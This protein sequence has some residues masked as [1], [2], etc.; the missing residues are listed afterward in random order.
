MAGRSDDEALR[1][2]SRRALERSLRGHAETMADGAH[3]PVKVAR[4]E[5]AIRRLSPAEREVLLAVR[6]TDRSYAEIAAGM[7]LSVTQ[8]EQLFAASLFEL[9]RN[10]DQP[11]R[12]GWRRWWNR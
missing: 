8:V 10:L 12:H 4:I 9:L 11:W 2:R 6:L 1:A 3:D 7:G 5:D